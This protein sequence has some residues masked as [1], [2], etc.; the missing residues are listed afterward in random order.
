MGLGAD[1]F[2]KGLAKK[3]WLKKQMV[4]PTLKSTVVIS[5]RDI[6]FLAP[7]NA[8]GQATVFLAKIFNQTMAAIKLYRRSDDMTD[9]YQRELA[10]LQGTS[11]RSIP[12]L[13]G[14]FAN[15]THLGLVL[16][17]LKGWPLAKLIGHMRARKELISLEIIRYVAV[18]LL[19]VLSYI[20]GKNIIH[21]DIAP[22]N[23]V[24]TNDGNVYLLDFGA[25]IDHAQP[26]SRPFGKRRYLAP[27]LLEGE[28]ASTV[29]DLYSLGAVLFEAV[30][31]RPF[32]G[33]SYR[34]EFGLLQQRLAQNHED[35]QMVIR[36]CLAPS[37]DLR[38]KSATRILSI[39][40]KVEITSTAKDKLAQLLTSAGPAN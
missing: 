13:L 9:C 10:I 18:E 28:P 7:I 8:G 4:I 35:L 20:L 12:K 36:A 26:R 15:E 33:Q 25:A 37:P 5:D 39:L 24:L 3:N 21:Q 6:Q 2:K 19:S 40:R 29:S 17:L 1:S 16:E 38:P 11:H 32:L 23:I 22:D 27:E 14:S 34:K 31:L 30:L